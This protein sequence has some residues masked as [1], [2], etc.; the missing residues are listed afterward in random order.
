MKGRR[1]VRNS[2][3]VFPADVAGEGPLKGLDPR[4]LGEPARREN[5]ADRLELLRAEERPRDGNHRGRRMGEG[6]MKIR[7]SRPPCLGATGARGPGDGNRLVTV[8]AV[9]PSVERPTAITD[10]SNDL[11][12]NPRDE[13]VGRDVL[14]DDGS[15]GN[16]RV[17]AD[18]E[19]AQD[20]R[21]RSDRRAVLDD[22]WDDVPVWAHGAR[23]RVVREAGMG[24]DE[25]AAAHGQPSVEGR[26]ILDLTFVPHDDLR[27]DVHVLAHVASSTDSGALP[28]LGP[29][30]DRGPFADGRVRRHLRGRVD[31]RRHGPST[32]IPFKV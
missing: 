26:K 17:P 28:D 21:V 15:R 16:H 20:R 1:A 8:S 22:R 7:R 18:R 4:A 12:G 14:R 3:R 11:R 29:V 13:G 27:V 23:V 5:F 19:T 32:R 25:H 24:S 9:H 10:P 31:A 6:A 2:D 30:P